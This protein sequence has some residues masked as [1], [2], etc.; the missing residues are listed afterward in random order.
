VVRAQAEQ[1]CDRLGAEA[2]GDGKTGGACIRAQGGGCV[3]EPKCSHQPRIE[4]RDG[5]R[6]CLV[7]DRRR[8]PLGQP[9]D[10]HRELA[11]G[12]RVVGPEARH[13]LRHQAVL[14][15]VADLRLRPGRL[16]AAL[17]FS[18]RCRLMRAADAAG[19]RRSTR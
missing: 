2:G 12:Q 13:G 7:R 14:D 11:L 17:D 19:S 6:R 16:A 18:R 9:A 10:Q 1:A 15:H 3:G 5:H 4:L 8:G